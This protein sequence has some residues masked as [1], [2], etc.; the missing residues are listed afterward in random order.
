MFTMFAESINDEFDITSLAHKYYFGRQ[1]ILSRD[2]EIVGYTL[3]LHRP[4]LGKNDVN[5]NFDVKS[6]IP[7]SY[8][9]CDL[10]KLFGGPQIFVT[11]GAALIMSDAIYCF[12]S[13]NLIL[14]ISESD[15][16]ESSIA[17]RLTGLLQDGFVFSLRDVGGNSECLQ[18]L[19]PLIGTIKIDVSGLDKQQLF[20]L[21]SSYRQVNTRLIAEKV[22]TVQQ[23]KMCLEC[24]FDDFQGYFFANFPTSAGRNFSPSELSI[25]HLMGLVNSEAENITIENEIKRDVTIGLNLLRLVNTPAA[26]VPHRIE[27][28]R[29]AL[30][31]LGRRQL[32]RW[33]QILIYTKSSRSGNAAP[34]IPLLVLASSRG[35]LLELIA[36]KLKPGNHG[37]A[38]MGFTIGIMSLMDILFGVP[39]NDLLKQISVFDEVANALLHR[40]G[41]FG[42][43]LSFV[44]H[45]E[46]FEKV[47][48]EPTVLTLDSLHLPIEN[49][50]RLQ[51]I[52]FDWADQIAQ[53]AC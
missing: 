33:L 19:L 44:E 42:E 14:E 15:A 40:K 27:S 49:F 46:Q 25:I 10:D 26:G 4:L 38:D 8:F 52:A 36:E 32:Q 23:F 41:F 2:Q 53:E 43:L 45:V 5:D 28:I 18:K 47:N 12:N 31:I 6:A 20:R 29:Q 7:I 11:V 24:G 37:M 21:C 30:L 34:P 51:L 22:Q 16:V 17:E 3:L 48:T 13:K 1:V 9:D 50:N 39:M 35:K